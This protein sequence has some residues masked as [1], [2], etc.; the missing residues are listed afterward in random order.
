[1]KKAIKLCLAL[2]GTLFVLGVVLH[3]TGTAMGGRRE[4]AQYFEDHWENISRGSW[5]HILVNSDE[6]HIGGENGLHVDSDGVSIGGEHGIHVGHHSESGHSDRKQLLQSGE[7]TNITA[8]EVD[9][10]CGDVWVQEGESFAV[11]LDWNLNNYNMS[12]EVEDGVL[13]VWDESWGSFKGLSDIVIT[14]KVLITVPA[15]AALDK[16]DLSTDMGDIEVDADLTAKKANLS[17]NLGDVN[18]LGLQAKELE[19]E[20]DLGDVALHLPG[21]REDY[22]WEL[23]TS[24]GD[25]LLDGEKQSGGMGDIANRGGSGKNK[26][27]AATSLGSIEVYFS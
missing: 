2:A 4:S 22:T 13:T 24:M 10:D 8:V 27:E 1:M 16:L 23:E 18:C 25:L 6:V 11:S 7:L 17:T 12:Y 21:T 14:C 15:G 3:L 19:A 26:V 20:S 9:V 5:G